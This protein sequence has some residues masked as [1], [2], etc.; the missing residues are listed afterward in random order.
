MF[1]NHSARAAR[2][3]IQEDKETFLDELV[4]RAEKADECG[5]NGAIYQLAKCAAGIRN[6][7]MK[8]VEWEDGSLTSSL[9]EY[10]QRFQDHF[11]N[12]FG[13]KVVQNLEETGVSQST[14]DGASKFSVNESFRNNGNTSMRQPPI[15]RVIK[16]IDVLP[17]NKAVEEDVIP[18]ELLQVALEPCAVK[19][20]GILRQVWEH[21][22]WPLNWRGGRLQELHKK[23][24]ARVFDNFRGL[25]VS[26][27]FGKAASAILYDSI[28]GPYHEYIPQA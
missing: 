3:T 23:G 20:H 4:T 15:Q 25:L 10:V 28:D 12:V 27:H 13:A 14:V 6:R 7:A 19:L 16:A 21:T 26:S 5:D 9:K 17:C 1:Y 2:C 8:V 18:A 11:S 24:S 22:Y